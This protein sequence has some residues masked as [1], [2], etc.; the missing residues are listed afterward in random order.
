M[1]AFWGFKVVYKVPPPGM[2]VA[3][4]DLGW[5][6]LDLLL[7]KAIILVVTIASWVGGELK[8]WENLPM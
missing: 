2:P 3:N 4:E 7:K 8:I 6:L 5:D 1:L